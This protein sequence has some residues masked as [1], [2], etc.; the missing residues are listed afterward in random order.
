M[1]AVMAVSF[2]KQIHQFRFLSIRRDLQLSTFQC[3]FV[4]YIRRQI[5]NFLVA[6]GSNYCRNI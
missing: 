2:D 4:R 3:A 6:P 1:A 5:L